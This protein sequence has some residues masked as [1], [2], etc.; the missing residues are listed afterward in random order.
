MSKKILT[1]L[2]VFLAL[3]LVVALFE[4]P[5]GPKNETIGE[6]FIQIS[7]ENIVA[8]EIEH[9]IQGFKFSKNAENKWVVEEKKTALQE[10]MEQTKPD[11]AKKEGA[12][13]KKKTGE[14]STP[15]VANQEM[16]ERMIDV[17]LALPKG[18]PVTNNPEKYTLFEIHDYG[19]NLGFFD[20]EGKKLARV[21][22]GKEGPDLF[23]SYVRLEGEKEVYLVAEQ[24]K[25]MLNHTLDEWKER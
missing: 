17:L 6:P 1:L 24:L 14:T 3:G 16:V 25:G 10:K 2:V 11:T 18:V 21:Y 13:D 20:K 19:L 9:F 5:F 4:K 23:S 12:K 8:I 7:K 15:V 22:I